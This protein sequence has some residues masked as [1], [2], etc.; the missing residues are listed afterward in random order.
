MGL[1]IYADDVGARVGSYSYVH[2]NRR[3][4]I[5]ATIQYL[6]NMSI[7][8]FRKYIETVNSDIDDGDDSIELDRNRYINRLLKLLQEWINTNN[9]TSIDYRAIEQKDE[10]VR[11]E[12][13]FFR[14]I[15]LYYWV[16]HSDCDGYLTPCEAKEILI[17]LKKIY[18]YMKNS[19]DFDGFDADE[20]EIDDYYL[21]SIFKN[22]V[23][24]DSLIVFA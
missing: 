3:D 17:T 12:L 19:D 7:E 16:Y 10:T 8:E 23:D 18:K 20:R 2:T 13:R 6:E 15:G 14:L 5:S 21:Y 11:N 24:T 4:W 1:D 9:R 22:S